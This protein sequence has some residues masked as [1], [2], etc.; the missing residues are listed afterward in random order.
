MIKFINKTNI[1]RNPVPLVI[2]INSCK[3]SF[4]IYENYLKEHDLPYGIVSG[5]E[6]AR[7]KCAQDL[8]EDFFKK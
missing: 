7:V 5:I 4:D 3:K 6:D 2:I 8:I 1:T